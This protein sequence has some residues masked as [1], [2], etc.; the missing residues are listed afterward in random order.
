[1]KHNL[2]DDKKVPIFLKRS[3]NIDNLSNP[4]MISIKLPNEYKEID[5]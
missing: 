3:E 5:K 1:M 2:Y 4:I